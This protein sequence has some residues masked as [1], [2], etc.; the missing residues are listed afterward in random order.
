ME[1]AESQERRARELPAGNTV[2]ESDG[3]WE[4]AACIADKATRAATAED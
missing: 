3:D 1:E 2:A 4:R